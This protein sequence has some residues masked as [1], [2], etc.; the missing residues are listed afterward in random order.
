MESAA[1]DRVVSHN[2][3]TGV[4]LPKVP[5]KK[6]RVLSVA[7]VKAL[8]DAMPDRYRAMIVVAAGTGMRWGEIAAL[9]IE[10]V[11]ILARSLDVKYSLAE[12]GG[13]VIFN[14]PKTEAGDR[15]VQLSETVAAWIGRHIEAFGLGRD[16]LIFTDTVGGPLRARNWRRRV[17]YPAVDKSVGRPM[18][19]RWLRNTH[20]TTMIRNGQDAKEVSEQVG[21]SKVTTTLD[22]YYQSLSDSGRV[23]ADAFDDIWSKAEEA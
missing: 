15:T 11:N 14:P 12:H 22:I 18:E 10:N 17:W 16:G 9:R 5:S 19:F 13:A 20:I 3:C 6:K 4:D 21:H 1:N 23:I 7:E 8:A 2:P